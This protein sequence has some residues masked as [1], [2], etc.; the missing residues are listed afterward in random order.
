M[1]DSKVKN[2]NVWTNTE[3]SLTYSDIKSPTSSPCGNDTAVIRHQKKDVHEKFNFKQ[4]K[5]AIEEDSDGTY[6]Y[7]NYKPLDQKSSEASK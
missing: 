5:E 2:N 1:T 7:N 6:D 3:F 4:P